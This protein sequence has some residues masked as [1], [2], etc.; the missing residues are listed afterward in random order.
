MPLTQETTVSPTPTTGPSTEARVPLRQK[1]SR[2]YVKLSTADQFGDYYCYAANTIGCQ[3]E[4]CYFRIAPKGNFNRLPIL[5]PVDPH[6]EP[7]S[8]CPQRLSCP[9][10]PDYLLPLS[11]SLAF[12]LKLTSSFARQFQI[13]SIVAIRQHCITIH[14]YWSN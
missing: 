2:L 10:A 5:Q 7:K 6:C 11:Q 4:P 13:R 1:A 8:C 14:C 12:P 9:L 3:I